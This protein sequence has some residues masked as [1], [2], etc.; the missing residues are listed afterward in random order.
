MRTMIIAA[1]A[2][3]IPLAGCMSDGYYADRP[4]YERVED[5]AERR[6]ERLED[7]ADRR[8]DRREDRIERRL[9]R[10]DRIYRGPDGRYYCQRDDGTTG[11][12][13][14][15]AAGGLLGNIVASGR[16]ETVGTLIGAAGGA[17]LGQAIDRGDVRCG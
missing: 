13:I 16:S 4:G 6:E 1:S 7:R 5:R 10:N 9:A 2:L 17:L 3:A 14:G 15:A 8:E 11:L 12:I